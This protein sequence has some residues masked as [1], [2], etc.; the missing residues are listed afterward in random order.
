MLLVYAPESK[1]AFFPDHYGSQFVNSFQRTR[2]VHASFVNEVE[3]LGIEVE[4]FLAAHS[5]N[6][7]TLAQLEEIAGG[8]ISE[9]C[10]QNRPICSN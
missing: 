4:K 9:L 10:Y 5:P 3:R 7:I 2:D 1:I 8:E 6:Q